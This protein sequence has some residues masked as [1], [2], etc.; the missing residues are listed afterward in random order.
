MRSLDWLLNYFQNQWM[1]ILPWWIVD[2]DFDIDTNCAI[3]SF[4]GRLN[5]EIRCTHP[6]IRDSEEVLLKMDAKYMNMVVNKL[7]DDEHR[8]RVM[9]RK[10]MFKE[11]EG[12]IITKM[13]AF[14][15]SFEDAGRNIAKTYVL[16]EINTRDGTGMS[17][18]DR[19][20]TSEAFALVDEENDEELGKWFDEIG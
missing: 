3:E 14:A 12:M 9:T 6:P 17:E 5:H 7:P 8:D 1:G 13:M 10:Q 2:D 4:H 18:T 20:V 16:P 15:R 19:R 11:K